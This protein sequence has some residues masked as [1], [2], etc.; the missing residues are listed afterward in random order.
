MGAPPQACR[1]DLAHG[2]MWFSTWDSPGVLKCGGRG[3]AIIHAAPALALPTFRIPQARW[4]GPCMG[5][6]WRVRGWSWGP[7]DP[8]QLVQSQDWAQDVASGPNQ[9]TWHQDQGSSSNVVRVRASSIQRNIAHG[10]GVSQIRSV[11]WPWTTH[12]ARGVKGL[13]PLV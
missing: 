12:P 6:G 11:D 3:M 4:H 1:P 9:P 7:V 10:I 5:S 13:A 2:A 8:I